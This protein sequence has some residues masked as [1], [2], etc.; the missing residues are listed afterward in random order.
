M[1]SNASI[2]VT[3]LTEQFRLLCTPKIPTDNCISTL[4]AN[5]TI[6]QLPRGDN[7]C[8]IFALLIF[9]AFMKEKNQIV[10]HFL[11]PLL[12][13]ILLVSMFHQQPRHKQP[14]M[15]CASSVEVTMD[16]SATLLS[17]PSARDVAKM[18]M[19]SLFTQSAVMRISRSSRL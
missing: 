2:A 19:W 6:H 17:S 3:V 16:L 9:M 12:L 5:V 15:I 4:V 8:H 7:L 13:F 10:T 14:L 11:N 18:D 1:N